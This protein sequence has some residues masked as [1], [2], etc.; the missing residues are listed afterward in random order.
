MKGPGWLVSELFF[1][2]HWEGARIRH[3]VS[4]FYFN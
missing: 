1:Y 4:D 3:S 2:I